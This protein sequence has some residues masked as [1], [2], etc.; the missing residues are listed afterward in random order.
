MLL[1]ELVMKNQQE[2]LLFKLHRLKLNEL[3]DYKVQLMQGICNSIAL[4]QDG[5]CLF[6]FV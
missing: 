6:F 4:N 5:I 2:H 1:T 3:V